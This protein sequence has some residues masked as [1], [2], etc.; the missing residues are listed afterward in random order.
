MSDFVPFPKI[1]RLKRGCVI[2]EKID[3]TNAQVVVGEDG[4][5]RAG[6]RNR[7][8]S[9]EDDNFG[10]ARWVAEHV[11]GL[12]ELGPGQH[13]GEWWGLG[14]QRGYGLHERR[15]SLFNAGRWSAGRP[16]CCGV[17]PVLYAGDFSTDVVD[18]T[19]Q[20]LKADG[21]AVA[22]GFDKPEGIIVYMTAARHT[23]KVLAENDNEP[24]GRAEAA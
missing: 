15:F 4:S 23:Y 14:I 16:E 3:G 6:S 5:V 8:I 13:F 2:T 1:P 7:W 11:D 17:V 20:A 19:L 24:K 18:A 12:R 10:F 22:P 9:P 21:S